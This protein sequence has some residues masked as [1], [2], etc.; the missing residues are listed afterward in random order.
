MHIE[1]ERQPG[2]K[3]I[4]IET[5]GLRGFNIG[6]PVGQGKR[7][8]LGR[9]RAGLADVVA[10]DRNRVPVRHL[11][12]AK[13]ENIRDDP[14][15]RTGRINIRAASDVLFE[16]IVLNGAVDLIPGHALF[17]RH[18]QVERQQNGRGSV[19]GHGG[20]DFVQRNA[21]QQGFHVRQRVDGHAGPPDFSGGHGVVG[22]PAHLRR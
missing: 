18:H 22:I 19:N 6:D 3:P 2:S 20:A 5:N 8:F 16:Q 10:G 14:Q 9:G 17:F 4:D 12:G 11:V 1:K 7:N 15:G 13:A 21:V